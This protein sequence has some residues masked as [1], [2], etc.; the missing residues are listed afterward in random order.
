MDKRISSSQEAEVRKGPW[1]M[2]EDLIL[3]NYIS[4]HGE[5]VWNNIARSAGLKRTGKSCRLRWLNYLRPDVRRGNI[6]PEEQQLIMELHARWG[7]RWSKIARQLPGRT[8]NEIKNFWRTRVQK[9]LKQCES[10]VSLKNNPVI[11]D[12]ASTSALRVDTA[13][14]VSSGVHQV[15]DD[16]IIG[17]DRHHADDMVSEGFSTESSDNF[18]SLEDF[19]TMKTLSF[20]NEISFDEVV[21]DRELNIQ[22]LQILFDNSV[23]VIHEINRIVNNHWRGDSMS[24]TST[25]AP[26]RELWWSEFREQYDE[27]EAAQRCSGSASADMEGRVEGQKRRKDVWNEFFEQN[28]RNPPGDGDDGDHDDGNGGKS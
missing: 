22:H 12:D 3:I 16:N 26:T 18:W 23:H 28:H 20:Y 11:I 9:K 4:N 24:Y 19:W 13:G 5:G 7:N 6:T 21:A 8:D 17:G 27:L 1:T 2:E 14:N 10:F 25:P 15:C